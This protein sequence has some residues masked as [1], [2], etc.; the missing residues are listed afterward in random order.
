MYQS[1]FQLYD[2]IIVK[3]ETINDG[4]GWASFYDIS[5]GYVSY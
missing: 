2:L 3:K 5:W 4:R 1:N